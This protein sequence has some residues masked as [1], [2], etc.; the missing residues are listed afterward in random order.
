MF[1]LFNE[2]FNPLACCRLTSGWGTGLI[3]LQSSASLAF[4]ASKLT[5]IIIH[6][7]INLTLT[8]RHSKNGVTSNLVACFMASISG[9]QVKS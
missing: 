1:P 4:K 6:F 3:W 9:R 5:R 2:C 8:D 7:I